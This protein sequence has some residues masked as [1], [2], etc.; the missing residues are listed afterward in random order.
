MKG[1][2]NKPLVLLISPPVYDFAFYDL[3]VKPWGLLRIARWLSEN[4]Y[5]TVFLNAL[6]Y[7]DILST[8]V[9]GA[10]RRKSD[11]SG[12]M[13]R[14]I[15]SLPAG[16]KPIPRHF[17]RYG[18]VPESVEFRMKSLPRKPDL[19]LIG[20]GMTYWYKGVEEISKLCRRHFPT[21]P[22]GIG[23]IY[24]T[25]MTD[26]CL[27]TCEPDFVSSGPVWPGMKDE[28]TSRGFP[29]PSSGPGLFPLTSDPVWKDSGVLRLNE[30]CPFRCDYCA[31]HCISPRFKGGSAREALAFAEALFRAWGTRD[32]AFYDD[33]LLVNWTDVLKPFLEGVLE[34]KLPLRFYNPNAL[35]IRYLDREKLELMHRAG[36]REIRMGYESSDDEFHRQKDRKSSGED[37]KRAIEAVR[38]S[39]FPLDRCGVY[40]L[41]GLPGQYP[42]EVEASIRQAAS[43]GVRCRIA[44]YS[45]VPGTALWEQSVRQS[46]YPLEEEPLYQNNSF[47]PLETE[48]F[49]RS[50]M[51]RLKRLASSLYQNHSR[52]DNP[53]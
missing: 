33:A 8:E 25:L 14:L 42:D 24:A 23:G 32:F 34:R 13:F 46:S 27:K 36:F 5:E 53:Y 26:H 18:I 45:P 12:K 22:V 16:V 48:A 43:T 11:G 20:S 37:F 30:G 28:L 29:V 50:D 2:Y 49:T 31:S 9:L 10:C 19:I 1:S 41:A 21:V 40:I 47:F 38:E 17:S 39:G 4:G 35:H 52:T 3:Y 7:Y 44:Q 6:D 51:E 15:Q